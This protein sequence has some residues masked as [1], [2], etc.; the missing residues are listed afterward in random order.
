MGNESGW[1]ADD[2]T[3]DPYYD[4]PIGKGPP[5]RA[6]YQHSSWTQNRDRWS[7]FEDGKEDANPGGGTGAPPTPPPQGVGDGSPSPAPGRFDDTT[8]RQHPRRGNQRGSTE[9]EKG[10]QRDHS[11]S[12]TRGRRGRC[13]SDTDA[14]GTTGISRGIAW[15]GPQVP[16]TANKWDDGNS[17][18]HDAAVQTPQKTGPKQRAATVTPLKTAQGANSTS[19]AKAEFDRIFAQFK[20]GQEESKQRTAANE[21]RTEALSKEIRDSTKKYTEF[22]ASMVAHKTETQAQFSTMND[23]LK[24]IMKKLDANTS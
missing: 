13:L 9:E 8:R 19:T 7:E 11:R 4:I 22:M 21:A 10:R 1:W 24:A 14:P 17:W 2:D 20:E 5:A 6:P 23:T 16:N 18:G 15:Q 3:H 12:P